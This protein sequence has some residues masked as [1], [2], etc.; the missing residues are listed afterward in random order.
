MAKN[1]EK[2][3]N[4]PHIL[5][6]W[7]DDIGVHNIS[8]YNHGIM[9]YQTPNID[10][11]AAYDLLGRDAVDRGEHERRWKKIFPFEK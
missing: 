7:G 6:I 11:T 1:I 8:A 5:V 3:G 4:Q 9:G 2:N 10:R